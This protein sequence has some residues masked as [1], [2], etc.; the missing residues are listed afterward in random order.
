MKRQMLHGIWKMRQMGESKI[1]AVQIRESQ[2]YEASI[3]GTVISCLRDNKA[4]EDPYFGTNE[5]EIRDMFWNDYE[6]TY[7]FKVEG[8]MLSDSS[9]DL[10]CQGLDTLADIYINDELLAATN[11]MHRTYRFPV[12]D[13]LHTGENQIRIL[14]HSTLQYIENYVSA[15]GKHTDYVPCGAMKGSQL[16]RKAHSMFGWDWGIQLPDAGIFRNI[17]LESYEAERI[18]KVKMKQ[19]HQDGIVNLAVTVETAM[20]G[21][22]SAEIALFSP[23]GHLM[24]KKRISIQPLESNEKENSGKRSNEK[25]NVCGCCTTMEILDPQLWWPNGYG[26]HPLYK[27]HVRV[28]TE[29]ELD[30]QGEYV[31]S[32]EYRIGLRT[33]TISQEPDQWGTEFAFMINGVRIFAKGANYIPEDAIYTDITRQKTEGL[34]KAAVRANFNCIRVW[35]GGYYP[36]DDFYD[37][38]DEAGLIVWQDLMFACNIY[39]ASDEFIENV[40]AE[41]RDNVA[42]IRHHACLGVWCGNN[43]IESAWVNWADFKGQPEALR[44]DYLKLFE[45][46]LPEVVRTEDTATFYWRS[47]PSSTGSFENPDDE[48]RGDVHY[49]QVWHGML[50]FTD[51]QNHYFRF[52]SEFGFQSFPCLKTVRTYTE[53]EDRNIFSQVMESHQKNEAANGKIL[54]YLSQNFLYPKDFE[55][56][57]YVSQLLQGI[58]IKAGVE[59]FRRNRGR[60]MGSLYWQ[61]NDN[62]PVAS[63]ASVDYFGR[64]KALHYMARNFYAPTA[65]S[66]VRPDEK[67]TPYS[68]KA[69]LQNESME[70]VTARVRMTL[71]DMALTILTEKEI[72]VQA[73]PFEVVTATEED[74]TEFL[75]SVFGTEGLENYLVALE[76]E[77]EDHTRQEEVLTFVPYKHLKLKKPHISVTVEEKEKEYH[78][79]LITDSFAPFVELDFEDADVIFS[80]NYFMMADQKAKVIRLDK[81]DIMKGSFSGVASLEKRL[82]IRSLWDSYLS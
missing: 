79:A 54:Y 22:M 78:I 21:N 28:G 23:E 55:S 76:V 69:V 39:E 12:G 26:E 35:G 77:Y 42:R 53:E 57:L 17:Y 4:I 16:V 52:C 62:W 45:E 30:S 8:G 44:Q 48:N 15:E 72:Q 75:G 33:L 74:Y 6:F 37:I 59:H 11:N 24:E 20:N 80:D 47:S 34:L 7:T 49:W 65:F 43:E 70:P 13:R 31:D 38:C 18:S 40:I 68:V 73:A 27:V 3:P 66:L 81:K 14:F 32:R 1:N 71:R 9:L 67:N 60:C 58:A 19:E 50:P 36:G 2:E 63:W 5:Y 82:R 51:Y 25:E 10:V 56:L 61:L 46:I 29:E 64:W 41:V